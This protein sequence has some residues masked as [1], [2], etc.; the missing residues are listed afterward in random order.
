MI[1]KREQFNLEGK[2]VL[3]RVVFKPPFKASSALDNEARFM[4][5][6]KGKS[7]LYSPNNQFELSTGNSVLMK[8]EN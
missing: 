7:R 3:G 1:I 5:V 6:I 4:H 2:V 8:C